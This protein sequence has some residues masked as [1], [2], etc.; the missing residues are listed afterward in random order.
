MIQ[1]SVQIPRGRG[2]ICFGPFGNRQKLVSERPRDT[3][4]WAV[5][6]ASEQLASEALEST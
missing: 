1:V 6:N 2:F 5:R 4:F 3:R